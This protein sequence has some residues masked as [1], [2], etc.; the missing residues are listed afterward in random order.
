MAGHVLDML[1]QGGLT[2]TIPVNPGP[3]FPGPTP[4]VPPIDV[5]DPI[6]GEPNPDRVPD[7]KPAPVPGPDEP[8]IGDVLND[9]S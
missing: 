4:P 6:P 3:D 9:L 5:P 8:S 7:D 2:V 1:N